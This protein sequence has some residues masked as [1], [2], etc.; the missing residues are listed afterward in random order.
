MIRRPPRST[1]FP[2]T[3]LFR[4][5]GPGGR[6]QYA[7]FAVG[8]SGAELAIADRTKAPPGT[9]AGPGGVIVH[10]RVDDLDPPPPPPPE[11][12]GKEEQGPTPPGAFLHPVVAHPL[13]Q[14][15]GPPGTASP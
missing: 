7:K 6:V 8:D 1:L 15:P 14:L 9:V 4:S 10:W 13:H 11:V 3:T 2:Y 5:P 12:G